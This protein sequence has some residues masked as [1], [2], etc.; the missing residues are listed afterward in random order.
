MKT[1]SELLSRFRA[2][3]TKPALDADFAEE[4]AQHLEAATADNIRSGMVPEEARRQAR[5][6]LG[7][8]DQTRELHR[9]TRGIPWLEQF[10]RDLSY[11]ARML[12]RERGFTAV[13]LLIL[14]VGIGLNTTVF[15]LVNTVLLRPIP[16]AHADRLVWIF[17]GDPA[18]SSHNLSSIA[19]R[20]DTWEGL[21]EAN[22]T[23]ERIEA[24]NPFSVRQTFRLTG[25][26]DPETILSVDVSHG[27]FGMLGVNPFLG[28]LFLPEDGTKN[29]PARVVLSH[30]LWQRRYG[31][32]PSIVGQTIQINGVAVEV[33]GV[34]PRADAFTSVF[35]PAVRVDTY[36]ALR[37][38]DARHW[39]NTVALIGRAKPGRSIEVI[40]ADLRLAAAQIKEQHPD[41]NPY[42]SANVI[43]LHDWVAGSL[44]RSLLF[45]WIAAG[46][47][48]AIVSF[49]LGGLLLARG[50]ARQKELALRCA[51]GAGRRRIAGQL[52]TECFALVATGSFLGGLIAW[53]FIHFLSVR[54]S[55][56]I[57]LLQN[58][59]LDAAALDFTVLLSAI[60]VALCG[61]LPVWKLSRISDI[62]NSL[63][64]EGRGSSGGR[65]RSRTRN[66]LVISEVALACVLAISAGLMVRSL[67]N[68]LTVDLGFQ[69]S[70]LIAVRIDPAG[71]GPKADYLEEILDR[72]RA[73]PGVEHAALTDCVPVERDRSW[74]LYPIIKDNPND[75][76]WTSAHIRIVSP[77]MFPAMGTTLVAGRDFTRA[78]GKNA[79][80]VIIINRSLANQFWPGENALGKQVSVGENDP[81]TVIGVAADVR[82]DGPEVPAG[83]EM[84]LSLHQADDASSWDL[85]VR[86]KLPVA[87]LTAGLRD[88]L[89]SIDATLPLTKV[90]T[91]Q[92]LVD[93]TL[94]SRR[95]LVWLIGGFAAIAVGL[96]ALGL[97]GV[98]SYMVT[99]QTKEIGIR[100]ALGANASTVQR[101]IVWQTLKLALGGL[102]VGLGVSLAAG[103][104]LQSLL[105]GVSANDP[106]NY[107]VA[108]LALLA[109]AFVAGY[110]PARRASRVDPLVALRAD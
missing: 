106:A 49:N 22:R 100:M 18:G 98:I 63:K 26:G 2:V 99:Q 82:H 70:N 6:A 31:A 40:R 102:V 10:G 66:V 95:L 34:L 72:V 104:G 79:P 59:R 53:G 16:F 5:I 21:Q 24:Y 47:V 62:Q 91:M 67:F 73:M 87:A 68:L 36:S 84:Y 28:R 90:R 30:E 96:A 46:L 27:L 89:R 97:Y 74:G 93:R 109:C 20:V 101:Q 80:R 77:G 8:F 45:L 4:L 14:A 61:V 76:R 105:Y 107:F 71:A 37:N 57:P 43:A 51:L 41:R 1:L 19:S 75:Q 60:T 7:G 54:S 33:I 44:K 78:D 12:R 110:L 56:E 86:T 88:G 17:N 108:A 69:P 23:L 29:A 55:V 13:A 38:E 52:L 58:L 92:T 65:S 64:D 81:H 85:M 25:S 50:T 9:E 94:S 32:D 15:S 42:F 48:L 103:R 35:F 83:N 3:F 11:A 39:S